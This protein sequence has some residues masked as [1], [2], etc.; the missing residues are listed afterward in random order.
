MTLSTRIEQAGGPSRGLDA[1]IELAICNWSIHH[2]DAWNHFQ[3]C[4]EAVNSPMCQPVDPSPYTTSLDAAMTL[5]PE[6]WRPYSADV[7]VK[8]QTRFL[9][10]GPK[11]QWGTDETGEKCAGDDW[12]SQGIAA[13]SA[14]ALC[15]AALKAR[16]L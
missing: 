9:I 14:L 16:G 1:E 6:G 5:V 7:S 13:T 4:G 8:G 15:A 2:F 3:E 11:T 10:E 12:Y